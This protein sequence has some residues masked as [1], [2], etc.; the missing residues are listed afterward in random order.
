MSAELLMKVTGE[1][2][3][4]MIEAGMLH[5]HAEVLDAIKTVRNSLAS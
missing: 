5:S 3:K 1:I 4:A 2:V